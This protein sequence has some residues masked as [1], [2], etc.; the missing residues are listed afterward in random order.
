MPVPYT[1]A[2]ATA[3]IPLSNLDSNFATAVTIGN[4][5]VQ[6]GNTITT[7]NNVTINSSTLS[8]CNIAGGGANGVVYINS[9]NVATANASVL[10]FAG[11]NLGIG[12]SSPSYKL[13]VYGQ[14]Y[15]SASTAYTYISDGGS[16]DSGN[17]A[18]WGN[19]S[20]YSVSIGQ[21]KPGSGGSVT[22]DMI[23]S[24]NSAGS[25][26]ERMRL[27]NPGNLLVGQ[28]SLNQTA[29]GFSVTSSGSVSSALAGSTNA[30]SSYNLYSTG[31]GAYRFYVDMA[32]TI[33]ATSGTIAG[34]SDATLKTN[35]KTL[36][37]GLTEINKLQPRRF[38]WI[39]GDGT[40]VAGFISQEVQAV[41][42]DL[43]AENLYTHNEDGSNVNKL[44]LKM[45]DMMPTVV[46][47]IQELSAQVTTLQSQVAALQAKVGA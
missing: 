9:S 15:F 37:T 19:G 31:A 21:A 8:S 44:Y 42:P 5:A 26:S 43:V 35:V 18:I 25:W 16:S 2:S 3:A 6:L 36:E 14:S 45:G 20:N 10:S 17:F 30:T 4:T 22:N 27:D 24:T 40:N 38:D 23:F 41:L 39:N 12:T 32:G 1:F 13:Q 46:K 11:T 47:A 28:T 29:L 7:L 34:V 33:H